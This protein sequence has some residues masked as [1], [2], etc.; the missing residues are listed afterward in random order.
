MNL[1]PTETQAIKWD[2]LPGWNLCVLWVLTKVKK[3]KCLAVVKLCNPSC[4]PPQM[5]LICLIWV[6]CLPHHKPR[7]INIF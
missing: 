2:T 6:N 5:T 4:Q 3:K 7:L 1:K